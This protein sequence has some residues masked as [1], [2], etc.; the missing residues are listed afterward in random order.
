MRRLVVV[1]H[2]YY[3]LA[4]P[5]VERAAHA[6]AEAGWTVTVVAL[7]AKGES[8]D[9]VVHEVRVRRLPVGHR[10]GVGFARLLGEYVAFVGLAT[11]EILR[12][13]TRGPI[14]VVHINAPPTFLICAALPARLRRARIVLDIH[15][16]EWHMYA[17]RFRSESSTIG[18]GLTAIT[19]MASRLADAVLTVHEPYR[20]ELV[21]SGVSAEKVTVMMN[22]PDPRAVARA[23]Q[24]RT[25]PS[26]DF[27]IAYHGTLTHWYGVDLVI[28][29]VKRLV[30][31]VP[32]VRARIIGDGDA[33][34]AL[35][36]QA[37][38]L[39][40]AER[41]EFSGRYLPFEKT[42]EAVAECSCGVVPNR[43]SEL[44]RFAL[45][46]KLFEYVALGLPAVVADLETLRLHFD[47]TEAVFFRA[48]DADALAEALRTI[49]QDPER[50]SAR[51]RAAAK[52]ADAYSWERQRR[53][54]LDLIS[55]DR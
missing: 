11:I 10:R 20:S 25:Q 34:P 19:R 21:K 32:S 6:A 3:P 27:V 41:I 46:S 18:R 49:A 26:R 37:R 24:A 48:G 42:L 45:S 1:V 47:E 43:P 12:L 5:R 36:V 51:V 4:E 53:I 50:A 38:E 39:G 29:A 33:L 44:N 22:T 8:R 16:L 13:A 2:A 15:D 35:R 17:A 30:P 52:R 14:D 23:G 9:E 31:D 7:R 28:D 55:Q 40:V 54:Y